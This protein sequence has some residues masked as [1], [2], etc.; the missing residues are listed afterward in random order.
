MVVGA[1]HDSGNAFAD[2]RQW[3]NKYE[4]MAE[5]LAEVEH[6]LRVYKKAI[7]ANSGPNAIDDGTFHR[8]TEEKIDGAESGLLEREGQQ[9]D[10][11]DSK[12][13]SGLEHIRQK[14]NLENITTNSTAT[15]KDIANDDSVFMRSKI[16]DH[17]SRKAIMAAVADKDGRGEVR[18]VGALSY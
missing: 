4:R 15:A 12:G 7:H 10:Y 5:R 13:I 16:V 2:A 11:A 3:R 9:R 1:L 18:C 6:E 14:M 8:A 17:L